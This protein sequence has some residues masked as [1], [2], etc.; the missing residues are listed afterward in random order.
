M[1]ALCFLLFALLPGG[2]S[3]TLE[4]CY[5]EA[6]RTHPY[7]EQIRTYEDIAGLKIRNLN[8]RYFPELYL[9]AQGTYQSQVME[10]PIAVPG[11]SVPKP[12]KTSY[13][14]SLL[15]NQ[16][17]YDF[18]Q[19]S[20]QKSLETA[21][22][23]YELQ[24]AQVEIYKVRQAVNNAYFSVLILQEK[25]K[26]LKLLE[27]EVSEKFKSVQTK[28]ENGTALPSSRDILEAELIRIRQNLTEIRVQ[29]KSALQTLGE[30]INRTPDAS[31]RL[32]VPVVDTRIKESIVR[33]RPEYGAFELSRN[34]LNK[35][36][37]LNNTKYLPRISGFA[38]VSYAKPGLNYF[39]DAFREYYIIGIKASWNFWNWNTNNREKDILRLQE[40]LVDTQE[41]YFTQNLN[42]AVYGLASEIEKLEE[43]IKM[44]QEIIALRKKIT[45]Q[46]SSQLD[47]G[48][49]TSTEYLTELNAEHQAVLAMEIH[50]IQ[51]IQA[52][53][54]YRTTIGE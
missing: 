21:Q 30:L 50:K 18:G 28:V 4:Q 12:L 32:A 38:Q 43:L 42:I 44:D 8:A 36:M 19:T 31:T 49:I 7:Q 15:V 41:K 24:S 3:L 25:E 29:M 5:E 45:Q 34:R 51:M 48:V 27:E 53:V 6:L 23:D 22:K 13:Q 37:S 2:D 14:A 10:L 46:V 16:L 26:S 11:F 20:K 54:N 17:I 39:N 40:K 1:N 52:K 47:N 9:S 35:T 33:K